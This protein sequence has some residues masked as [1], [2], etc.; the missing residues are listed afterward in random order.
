MFKL[1]SRSSLVI[2]D[3][4]D[5]E[6]D[7]SNMKYPEMGSR[8]RERKTLDTWYYQQIR[9]HEGTQLAHLDARNRNLP[10]H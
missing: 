4:R 7:L 10:E 5:R 1:V 6:Y 2:Y 8:E 3:E 9:K